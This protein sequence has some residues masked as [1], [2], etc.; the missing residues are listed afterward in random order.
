M[1]YTFNSLTSI[2][3]VYILEMV[4]IKNHY[5]SPLHQFY[6]SDSGAV[7][8]QKAMYNIYEEDDPSEAGESVLR[9]EKEIVLVTLNRG[10]QYLN[11]TRQELL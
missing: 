6:D 8:I 11:L 9:E 10:I 1:L 5:Q 7:G 3:N 4:D 2:S